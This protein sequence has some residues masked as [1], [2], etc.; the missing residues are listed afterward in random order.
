[1]LLA[2]RPSVPGSETPTEHV[3]PRGIEP[4]PEVQHGAHSAPYPLGAYFYPQ[5]RTRSSFGD[6]LIR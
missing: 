2:G 1:M 3:N 4:G 5:R 6:G